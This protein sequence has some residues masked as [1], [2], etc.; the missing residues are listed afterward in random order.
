M[1]LRREQIIEVMRHAEFDQAEDRQ[2]TRM[3]DSCP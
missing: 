1:D 3:V 2:L